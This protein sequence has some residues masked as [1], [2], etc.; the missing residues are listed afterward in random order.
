MKSAWSVNENGNFEVK[1]PWKIDPCTIPNNKMI[2]R[3]D[4]L[5]KQLKQKPEV[6]KLV[7]EQI[8]EM[9][10]QWKLVDK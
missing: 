3:D 7:N 4:R 10:K 9:I 5:S 1:L 8:Q 2:Q 6:G